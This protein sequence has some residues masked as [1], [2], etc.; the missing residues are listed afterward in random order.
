MGTQFVVCPV[1][2][3]NSIYQTS[4]NYKNQIETA[5][6]MRVYTFF[7]NCQ[8][9]FLAYQSIAYQIQLNLSRKMCKSQKYLN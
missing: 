3:H 4:V 5:N 8:T 9:V 7:A 6:D 2:S 1:Y